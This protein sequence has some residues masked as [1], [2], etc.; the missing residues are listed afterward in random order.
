MYSPTA[1]IPRI[2][3][4]DYTVPEKGFSVTKGMKVVISAQGVHY[5]PKIYP[6]PEIFDPSRFTEE[7]KSKRHPADFLGFGLGPRNCNGNFF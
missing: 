4:K 2:C 6:N 5:D 3:T 7:E 1:V